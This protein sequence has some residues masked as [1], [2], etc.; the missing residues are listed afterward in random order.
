MD[1]LEVKCKAFIQDYM[2]RVMDKRLGESKN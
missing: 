2:A 1:L